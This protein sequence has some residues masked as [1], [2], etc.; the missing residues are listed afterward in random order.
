MTSQSR[1]TLVCAASLTM[2]ALAAPAFAQAGP[3]A[4]AAGAPATPAPAQN[5]GE[6]GAAQPQPNERRP[7]APTGCPYRDGKLD[8]IV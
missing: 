7:A 2:L 1:L 3:A 8:L 4:G 6:N 5:K